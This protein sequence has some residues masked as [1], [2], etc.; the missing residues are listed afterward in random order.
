MQYHHETI[1]VNCCHCRKNNYLCRNAYTS[2]RMKKTVFTLLAG[3]ALLCSCV[4]DLS[5]DGMAMRF[6]VVPGTNI[7][8]SQLGGKKYTEA[9]F[10]AFVDGRCYK[11]VAVYDCYKDR[12][13]YYVIM[14]EEDGKYVFNALEGC[15]GCGRDIRLING[16]ELTIWC[17]SIGYETMRLYDCH[18]DADEQRLVYS[19]KEYVAFVNEEYL[20]TQDYLGVF[21]E[22]SLDA[23]ATFSRTVYQYTD[24]ADW[25]AK[26]TVDLRG[27]EFNPL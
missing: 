5:D 24:E 25:F 2:N 14:R 26:D 11:R 23:G 12:G 20:I 6:D 19:N 18:F 27:I 7:K 9:E 3:L 4:K 21:R 1:W 13:T 8:E 22:S 10:K 15:D 17:G 16:D